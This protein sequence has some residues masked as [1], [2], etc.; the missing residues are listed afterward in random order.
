MAPRPGPANPRSAHTH[1]SMRVGYMDPKD[2]WLSYWRGEHKRRDCGCVPHA[3]ARR[4]PRPQGPTDVPT[5][6]APSGRHPDLGVAALHVAQGNT[7][8]DGV[9]A[10]DAEDLQVRVIAVTLIAL[11]GVGGTMRP[12]GSRYWALRH[13][14][15]RAR[16]PPRPRAQP[17][18]WPA[19]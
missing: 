9:P 17:A 19:G 4:H 7:W 10:G 11:H 1:P 13:A 5:P 18:V 6:S 16:S 15:A 12:G 8:V 2:V 14:H 3:L